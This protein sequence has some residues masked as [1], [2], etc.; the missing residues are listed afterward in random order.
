MIFSGLA[1]ASR[2]HHFRGPMSAESEPAGMI[3]FDDPQLA[4]IVGEKS[5]YFLPLFR[6]FA[7][8]GRRLSWNWEA[9][10]GTAAWLSYRKLYI[11]GFVYGVLVWAPLLVADVF[12]YLP[13]A[14]GTC[15]AALQPP[16]GAPPVPLLL[17]ALNVLAWVIPPLVA[18]RIYYW[19]VRRLVRKLARAQARGKDV[20]S[21][22]KRDGGTAAVGG[23]LGLQVIVVFLLYM[24][25]SGEV[26]NWSTRMHVTD[27]MSQARR[28]QQPIADYLSAQG[29]L[30]EST[31][32]LASAP[33]AVTDGKLVVTSGGASKL[34]FDSRAGNLA[35][36][37]IMMVPTVKDRAI[38]KWTCRSDDIPKMCMPA[39]CQGE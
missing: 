29:R 5:E 21:I 19:H 38:D 26:T 17:I 25:S 12:E 36:H 27:A 2:Q 39:S 33:P 7:Q 8:G 37:S 28:L 3:N 1:K 34:V 31:E 4:A 32:Q 6:E 15:A 35:N 24:A 14:P 18:D 16:Q 22:L 10:F 20:D 11:V 13:R 9:F 23:V 30:P